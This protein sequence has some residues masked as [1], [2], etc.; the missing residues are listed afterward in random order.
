M[1]GCFGLCAQLSVAVAN[2]EGESVGKEREDC[3][4]PRFQGF[5]FLVAGLVALGLLI[6][7]EAWWEAV[8]EQT[9]VMVVRKQ[10]RWACPSDLTSSCWV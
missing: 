5:Q 3:S 4:G 9:V 6:S 7:S 10:R 1:H 8:E 2:A